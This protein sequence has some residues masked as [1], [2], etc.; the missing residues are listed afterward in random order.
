MT[1]KQ[2]IQNVT[3]FSQQEWKNEKNVFPVK[4]VGIGTGNYYFPLLY[5]KLAQISQIFILSEQVANKN[6]TK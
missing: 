5:L 6:V 2:S 4:K 1:N 3:L